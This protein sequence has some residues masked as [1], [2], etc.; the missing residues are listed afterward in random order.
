MFSYHIDGGKTSLGQ[1]SDE[2]PIFILRPHLDL[3]GLGN[4][5]VNYVRLY[6]EIGGTMSESTKKER[7]IVELTGLEALL[8]QLVLDIYVNHPQA[9]IKAAGYGITNEY[10]MATLKRLIK[11]LGEQVN[12]LDNAE[13][14]SKAFSSMLQIFR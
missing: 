8:C 3:Y 4:S 5:A 11:S 7:V 10:A 14:T 1:V 6:I 13:D 2:G 12:A 9:C